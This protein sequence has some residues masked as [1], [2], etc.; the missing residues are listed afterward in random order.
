MTTNSTIWKAFADIRILLEWR[1]A[2]M[3]NYIPTPIDTSDVIIPN[4]IEMLIEEIA[5]NVHEVWAYTRIQD[6]WQYGNEQNK[7]LKTTPCLVPYNQLPESEKEY[8]RNTAVETIRIILKLGY[9]ITR[10]GE[11]Q[12]HV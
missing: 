5:E 4:D 11:T 6:G 1:K 2:V 7:E 9:K 10:Q 12:L 3:E 8:D